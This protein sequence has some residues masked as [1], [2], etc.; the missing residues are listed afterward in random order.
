MNF[1]NSSFIAATNVRLALLTLSLAALCGGCSMRQEKFATP[2]DA[3]AA[4]VAA[5]RADDR[6]RVGRILGRGSDEI[7]NSGDAVADRERRESFLAA[8]DAGNSVVAEADGGMTLQV[9]KDNWPLPIPIVER[10]GGWRFDSVRGREEVLNRR[11]G[12][13][14][15]SSQQ[16]CLAIVDAQNEYASTDRDGNGALDYAQKIIS[17][18]GARNGLYYRTTD[19]EPQS[20]LGPLVADAAD[21]G[22]TSR[23]TESGK[24]HPY[25]GYYF[26]ILTAQGDS[27]PGGAKNYVVNGRMTDGFAV[28]AW[29]AEYGNSGVMTFMVDRNGILYERNLGRRTNRIAERMTEFDPD[30]G[31]TTE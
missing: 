23:R 4:L 18:P 1:K 14:E 8:Y 13:N 25:H 22:Y 12:R 28:L 27:A 3:S 6:E 2:E 16:V 15:L 21:E 26:K 5:V 10:R 20:P 9:G 31:W 17:D 7:M 29:P 11:I 30:S 19:D 24:R